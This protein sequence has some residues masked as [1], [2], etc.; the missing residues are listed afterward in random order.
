M[1]PVNRSLILPEPHE[2]AEEVLEIYSLKVFIIL[3]L[4]LFSIFFGILLHPFLTSLWLNLLYPLLFFT[5][6]TLL[7]HLFEFYFQKKS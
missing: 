5:F 7:F 1:K 3:D 6:F 4:L 2:L